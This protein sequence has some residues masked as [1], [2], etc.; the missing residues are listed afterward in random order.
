MNAEN[1]PTVTNQRR[2]DSHKHPPAFHLA[3]H[4]ATGRIRSENVT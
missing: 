4:A 3:R 2:P 1:G